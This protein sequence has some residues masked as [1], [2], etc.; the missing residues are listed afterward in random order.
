MLKC[1]QIKIMQ[2]V[3]MQTIYMYVYNVILSNTWYLFK[4]KQLR[5]TSWL[6]WLLNGAE[7]F[8]QKDVK[9]QC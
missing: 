7:N 8:C 5:F 4:Y 6:R 9:C 1:F 2:K 3:N